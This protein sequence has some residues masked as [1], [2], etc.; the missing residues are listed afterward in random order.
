[1]FKNFTLA[2]LLS[3][4]LLSPSILAHSEA[5]QPSNEWFGNI[6]GLGNPTEETRASQ[7]NR[8]YCTNSD[9]TPYT[10]ASAQQVVRGQI[11]YYR[12]GRYIVKSCEHNQRVEI[13]Q[14]QENSGSVCSETSYSISVNPNQLNSFSPQSTP[15]R[16]TQANNP[17]T[18]TRSTERT[19]A[20]TQART[21]TPK[22][23][24]T[25][26]TKPTTGTG[27]NSNASTQKSG[28]VVR[29]TNDENAY[30]PQGTP[31]FATKHNNNAG[32]RNVTYYPDVN[33]ESKIPNTNFSGNGNFPVTPR[34]PSKQFKFRSYTRKG[35]PK[36]NSISQTQNPKLCYDTKN[37]QLKKGDY[38]FIN[39]FIG[40]ESANR[41]YVHRIFDCNAAAKSVQIRENGKLV[42]RQT[43]SVTKTT[44][45]NKA[46]LDLYK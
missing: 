9:A 7:S 28:S 1:M 32:R 18:Q 26:Q 16:T 45:I 19:P 38:V 4:A 39:K 22:T 40:T 46:K 5:Q 2:V 3:L 37:Q 23:E 6:P 8:N 42:W 30:Y 13:T 21:T 25:N 12:S 41:F 29:S 17:Q 10:N 14:C 35:S 11:Q 15:A 31:A 24:S 43:N 44:K 20:Q 34:I 33:P 36:T 27:N